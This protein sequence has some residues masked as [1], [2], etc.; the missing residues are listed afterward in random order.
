MNDRT[1]GQIDFLEKQ[2]ISVFNG[3]GFLCGNFCPMVIEVD[4]NL[5]PLERMFPF[6]HTGIVARMRISPVG[7]HRVHL[8]KSCFLI[9]RIVTPQVNRIGP[10]QVYVQLDEMTLFSVSELLEMEDCND[11]RLLN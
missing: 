7:Y 8:V 1:A 10:L 3:L 9:G 2:Q 6:G 4:P 5:R 11:G